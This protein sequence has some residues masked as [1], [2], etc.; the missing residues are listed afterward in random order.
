M[1]NM[2]QDMT[3][4]FEI[5]VGS[6]LDSKTEE[7][8][9]SFEERC[10]D[11][12]LQMTPEVLDAPSTTD[13]EIITEAL[14][15]PIAKDASDLL[16]LCP[17]VAPDSD[18]DSEAELLDEPPLLEIPGDVE[19]QVEKDIASF[20]ASNSSPSAPIETD[21]VI[22]S[23]DVSSA[24]PETEIDATPPSAVAEGEKNNPL[25][26]S[27]KDLGAYQQ[28]RQSWP[29][30]NVYDGS[31]AFRDFY[32]WKV[33]YLR[34]LLGRFP[35][36][37]LGDMSE[38]LKE[39]PTDH[40]VGEDVIN[41]DLIGR[42]ID[43]SHRCRTRVGT[44]LINVFEQSYPW[45]RFLDM[46]RAKLFKDHEIKGAHRRD[47]TLLEHLSDMEQYVAEM[48]GFIDAAKH[49]DMMLRAASDSLSRQLTCLQIKNN[50]GLGGP[51]VPPVSYSAP[52][53][54]K[55]KKVAPSSP[56]LDDLDGVAE[57]TVISAP[58]PE[59]S[60]SGASKVEYG[61]EDEI[62]TLLG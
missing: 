28:I 32:R 39:V 35:V 46:L 51:Q 45:E 50:L 47:A 49:A 15:N 21:P 19:E 30:F 43:N 9:S 4:L 5:G 29:Q 3:D 48:K 58:K 52:S 55:T 42:K 60:G 13:T 2:I 25:D 27:G 11:V 22:E 18:L 53:I 23:A 36:L 10:K 12:Q 6:N 26:L 1:A 7:P 33:H 20:D 41:P 57:G 62:S 38:E 24:E 37:D 16:D 61:Q 8:L 14:K 34:I 54:P 59:P 17:E 56:L 31:L 44:L 40:F